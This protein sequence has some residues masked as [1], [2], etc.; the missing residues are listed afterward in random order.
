M[1]NHKTSDDMDAVQPDEVDCGSF[2]KGKQARM[3]HNGNLVRPDAKTGDFIFSDVCGPLPTLSLG[4]ARYFVA[5]IDGPT[6]FVTVRLMKDKNEVTHE[7]VKFKV[8]FEKQKQYN[9]Q[10]PPHRKRWGVCE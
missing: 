8:N 2:A 5:F 4:G 3:T 10:A 6:R 1:L 7:F 9:Y